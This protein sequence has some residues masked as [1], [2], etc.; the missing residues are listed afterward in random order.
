MQVQQRVIILRLTKGKA[1]KP[2]AIYQLKI[3]GAL[4]KSEC[5]LFDT[6]YRFFTGITVKTYTMVKG[7]RMDLLQSRFQFVPR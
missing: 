1:G 2:V 4:T 5:P 7:R 6:A 3:T